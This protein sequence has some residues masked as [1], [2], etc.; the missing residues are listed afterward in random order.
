MPSLTTT[1]TQQRAF[2]DEEWKKLGEV[3][4]LFD[5]QPLVVIKPNQQ[6]IFEQSS[7]HVHKD[8]NPDGFGNS[9]VVFPHEQTYTS[10]VE[11]DHDFLRY[12]VDVVSLVAPGMYGK[13]IP[14]LVHVSRI[15][16]FEG[17][18]HI[19]FYGRIAYRKG[20]EVAYMS[21][22]DSLDTIIPILAE[23]IADAQ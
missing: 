13:D 4:D 18:E 21:K 22:D 7:F 19:N 14:P 16:H 2:T 17:A 8:A 10:E 3:F 12:I 6:F 11:G 23:L 9:K 5:I 1:I 15:L 20:D